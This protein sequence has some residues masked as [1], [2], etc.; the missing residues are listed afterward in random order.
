M[1]RKKAA[2][3]KSPSK[4]RQRPALTL[5]PPLPEPTTDAEEIAL[6]LILWKS[7]RCHGALGGAGGWVPTAE[8]VK[9]GDRALELAKRVGVRDEYLRLMFGMKLLRVS[10]EPMEV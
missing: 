3:H 1:T 4:R 6:A 10:I 8:S 7:L 9:A 5:P 2:H